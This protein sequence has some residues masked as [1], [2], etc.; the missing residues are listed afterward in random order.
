MHFDFVPM[1]FNGD[2]QLDGL[3]AY[4]AAHDKPRAVLAIN[5]PNIRSQAF[6]SPE[7]TA[8]E[9]TK[10]KAIADKY[11]VPVIGPNMA[12]GSGPNDSIVELDPIE[13]KVVTYRAMIPFLKAFD[14]FM[15][16]TEVAATA[17]HSYGNAGEMKWAVGAMH[18]SF[19]KPVWVTEFSPRTI[20][21][22]QQGLNYLVKVTD[23]LEGSSYVG[24]YAWFKERSANNP[25]VS[26]LD[27]DPG[28]LTP[29]GLAY[30]A[31]PVHDADVYYRIPGK[32]PADHY[33]TATNSEIECTTD[34]NGTFD[35]ESHGEGVL[36]YNIQ[37]D[38]A[39]SYTL[40][41]RVSG[42]PGS[43]AV[44]QNDRVL[45]TTNTQSK[46]WDNTKAVVKLSAG[47]QTLRIQ[48]NGQSINWIEF[49]KQ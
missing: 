28:K 13:K 46:T 36:D 27:K 22:S 9:Y 11:G 2:I 32:L 29:M 12:M 5:E 43:I 4:M 14:F 42:P 19:G 30:V 41:F 39:G 33:L 20:T 38:K 37:V 16:S 21:S 3:A 23:F 47:P 34:D 1:V 8:G 31:L 26:L 15:G 48:T 40:N 18:Q 49:S 17:F 7:V 44:V 25:G 10:I 6:I 35:M 24:G 45:A